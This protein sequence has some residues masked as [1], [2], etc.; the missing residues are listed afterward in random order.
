MPRINLLP[1]RA[2][3]RQQRKKEFLVA[4][5]GAAIVGGV[6]VYGSKLTLQGWISN[7]ESRNAILKTEIAQLDKQIEEI[8]GLEN[9]RERLL[10]R[11]KVIGELQRSRPEV[12]H[13]F[14]EIVNALPEG[15]H[16]TELKQ[17]G[18]RIELQGVAQSSTRVSTLMRNIDASDWLSDPSLDGIQT[19]ATGQEHVSQFKLFAQQVSTAN[20]DDAKPKK[21]DDA[22]PKKGAAK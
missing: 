6:I 20:D 21:G 4:L 9:Q 12:V 16:L 3:L 19:V 8:K 22:K 5:L 11:M 13:L 18:G 2:A 10:A 7:Q 1:W 17:T 14:D 15:V